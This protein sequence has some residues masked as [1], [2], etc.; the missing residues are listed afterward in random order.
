M[1]TSM[2][3]ATAEEYRHAQVVN[4]SR[5]NS[6]KE[7]CSGTSTPSPQDS[8]A[9]VP[10]P[11]PLM[12]VSLAHAHSDH[13]QPSAGILP[14][15]YSHSQLQKPITD[16]I[17]KTKTITEDLLKYVDLS[18]ERSKSTIERTDAKPSLNQLKQTQ[19]QQDLMNSLKQQLHQHQISSQPPS[20]PQQQQQQPNIPLGNVRRT[21]SLKADSRTAYQQQNCES[22]TNSPT[23]QSTPKIHRKD[24]VHTQ[25]SQFQSSQTVVTPPPIGPQ[26][27]FVN[28]PQNFGSPTHPVNQQQGQ[29]SGQSMPYGSYPPSFAQQMGPGQQPQLQ[30]QYYLPGSQSGGYWIPTSYPQPQF[31][32]QNQQSLPGSQP[33][34]ENATNK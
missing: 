22:G 15:H 20:A 5:Q 7:V 27:T 29:F 6:E 30:G 28:F 17:P 1:A 33:P 34:G 4:L 24:V 21:Q 25:S 19:L 2:S 31:V 3:S 16:G 8:P 12:Q 23:P 9:H 10:L 14:S 32:Q 18:K 13:V 11:H 26:P